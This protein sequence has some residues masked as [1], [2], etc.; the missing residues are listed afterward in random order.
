MSPMESSSRRLYPGLLAL[1]AVVAL[2]GG[3]LLAG[4]VVIAASLAGPPAV[5][6]LLV[7]RRRDD[8]E[9]NPP[10]DERQRHLERS[11]MAVG[12]VAMAVVGLAA[13]IYELGRGLPL[14]ELRATAVV[15]V[16]AL[17]AVVA[18][19]VLQRRL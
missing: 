17:S 11:V 4:D 3:G 10:L 13:M 1:V 9:V 15:L 18:S 8:E 16:G 6:A 12:F 5:L 2:V 7:W 19:L 14:L